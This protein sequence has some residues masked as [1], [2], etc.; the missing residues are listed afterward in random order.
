[1]RIGAND[2]TVLTDDPLAALNAYNQEQ[3][4]N[5]QYKLI[6]VHDGKEEY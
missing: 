1:M 6:I 4:S 3:T 2:N 5:E